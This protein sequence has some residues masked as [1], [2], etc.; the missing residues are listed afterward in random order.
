MLLF[1]KLR[2]AQKSASRIKLV[3]FFEHCLKPKTQ[4]PEILFS[5]LTDEFQDVGCSVLE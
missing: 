1:G 5:S 4:H 3:C 2:S